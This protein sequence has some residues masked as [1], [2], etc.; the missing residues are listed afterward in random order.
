MTVVFDDDVGANEVILEKKNYG[1]PGT[2]EFRKNMQMATAPLAKKFGVT[3]HHMVYCVSGGQEGD[4]KSFDH[5]QRIITDV[6]ERVKEAQKRS[7]NCDFGDICTSAKLQG[8][9]S[10]EDPSK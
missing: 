6:I 4:Q 10:A 9:L 3:S 5:V 8:N 2:M 1:I 7:N